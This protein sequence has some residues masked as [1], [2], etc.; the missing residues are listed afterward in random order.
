MT[1]ETTIECDC[2][3]NPDRVGCLAN[4]T[5][6]ETITDEQIEALQIEAEAVGDVEQGWLCAVALDHGAQDQ[7]SA[8]L[9]CVEAI[10]EAELA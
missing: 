1:N 6:I 10:R 8:R 9:A 4:P 5:T 7:R 3:T 2:R